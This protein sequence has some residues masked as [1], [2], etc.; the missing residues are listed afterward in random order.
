MDD[1]GSDLNWLTG[2]N[3]RHVQF[4]LGQCS[5]NCRVSNRFPIFGWPR[6][7]QDHCI[8]DN[9]FRS[10]VCVQVGELHA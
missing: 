3:M 5:C 7:I 1:F 6:I 2:G 8:A 4:L 9:C 10:Q